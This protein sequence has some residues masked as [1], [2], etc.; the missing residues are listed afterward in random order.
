MKYMT[1][2]DIIEY[3]RPTQSR[4]KQNGGTRNAK[5][6]YTKGDRFVPPTNS[7]RERQSSRLD[8]DRRLMESL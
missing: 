1:P 5:R 3:D 8:I 7:K 4:K 6:F 2:L